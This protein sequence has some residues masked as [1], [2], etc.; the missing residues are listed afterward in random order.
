MN[1]GTVRI[2]DVLFAGRSEEEAKK[3]VQASAGPLKRSR[4]TVSS[5]I[6]SLNKQR[7]KGCKWSEWDGSTAS[8][9]SGARWLRNTS[10]KR[11]MTTFLQL[12][13]LA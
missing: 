2:G 10:G 9:D 4:I 6:S 11:C 3:L 1:I 13:P 12:H 7:K 5:R 8:K